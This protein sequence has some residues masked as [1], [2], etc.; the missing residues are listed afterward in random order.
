MSATTGIPPAVTEETKAFWDAA[1]EGRLLV[2][3][4]AACGAETYATSSTR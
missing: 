3:K 1:A 2:E 4:C